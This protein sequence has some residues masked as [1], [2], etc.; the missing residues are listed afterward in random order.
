MSW[1]KKYKFVLGLVIILYF[2][3][4][5]AKDFSN[6]YQRP[7]VGDAKA[8]YAYLPAIFIY[9]DAQYNF[10][11]GYESKYYAKNQRKD[12][13]NTTKNGSKVNKTFPGVAILYLPFFFIAHFLASIFSDSPDGYSIIYQ[14]L[15]DF[16]Y[17]F[18][19]LVGAI[20]FTKVFKFLKFKTSHINF[21]IL[22]L[23]LGTNIFFYSVI[24]QS[25][26]HIFNFALINAFIYHLLQFNSNSKSKHLY[27]SLALILL[28]GIIRPTNI[29]VLLMIPIFIPSTQIYLNITKQLFNFKAILI[30]SVITLTI[31][32]IPF[33]LWKWQTDLWIVYGYGDETFDFSN[34]EWFNFLFSYTKGWFL[35]TP[36]A[37][38]GII[39]GLYYQ[40]KINKYPALIILLFYCLSVYVFS[41]WWCWYYGAGM[42]QRVMIDHYL[43][44]GYLILISLKN[45]SLKI[46]NVLIFSIIA[47]MF[48]NVIQAIQIKRG[49]YALG[50]PTKEIY[51]DNFLN[52]TPKAKVYGKVNLKLKSEQKLNLANKNVVVKGT[53]KSDTHKLFLQTNNIQPYSPTLKVK[54]KQ[55]SK[56]YII[57]F[58]AFA[59]SKIES[60]RLV[61]NSLD[62]IPQNKVIYLKTY[63]LKYSETN[64]EFLIDFEKPTFGF[65][66][67][68]WNGTS[69]E[70]ID[71]YDIIVEQY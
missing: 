2:V 27:F 64:L 25:V 9:N 37:F 5:L 11:D 56:K 59:Q 31:G 8:Y 53:A 67:Y 57:N 21:S 43:I 65:E 54:F 34:P 40:F 47:L 58:S 4:L 69:Q 48:F 16:G 49:I 20:Y 10:I 7:I 22:T 42:G 68:F 62:S 60:T 28:I 35:Y 39:V 6:P 61:I 15:F 63:M 23:I 71:Y 17:W 70:K 51:W 19:L 13:L 29:I 3:H 44:L 30:A 50:S 24:D 33:I 1:L 46:Q 41:S 55:A 14:Y 36:I 66:A 38:I 52:L 12:F 32:S 45:A 26:T 18:Y